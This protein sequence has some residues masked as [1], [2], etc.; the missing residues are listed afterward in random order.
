MLTVT[1]LCISLLHLLLALENHLLRSDLD[2]GKAM[3]FG[4]F[5]TSAEQT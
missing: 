4:S 5:P 3:I 1:G 2:M